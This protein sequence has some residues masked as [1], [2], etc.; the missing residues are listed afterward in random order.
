MKIT[1]RKATREDAPE[2]HKINH[3]AFLPLY[4]KYHDDENP[5]NMPF[6]EI[7]GKILNPF[8]AYYVILA[9]D[10]TAGGIYVYPLDESGEVMYLCSV[11]IR[12]C[13]QGN[14]IAQ[15]AIKY[16]ESQLPDS[17]RWI[18]EVP[19]R[20]EKNIHIYEKAGYKRTEQKEKINDALTI[21]T[22]IKEN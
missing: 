17:K 8:G 13:L 3:E 20:E 14:S 19:E 6:E 7:E 16:A 5:A 9:D 1:F 10:E 18:L 21:V 11:Y 2:Q 12:P 22:Y 4:E 15:T